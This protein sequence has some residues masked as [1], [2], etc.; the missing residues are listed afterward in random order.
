M[1]AESFKPLIRLLIKFSTFFVFIGRAWQHLYW[2]APYRSLLWDEGL[3]KPIVETLLGV[4][5]T[6]Y[7]TATTTDVWIQ[8]IIFYTGVLYLLAGGSVLFY[9][10]YQRKLLRILIILGGVN[11]VFLSFL[12]M[13]E[14]FYHFAQFFEHAIQ[15][16]LPFVFLYQIREDRDEV[17]L[18]FVLKVL[19]AIVFVSH[20]LYAIGYYPVP[21][22]F[23]DMVMGI[24][25]FSESQAKTFLSIA[26]LMD[27]LVAF[28]IFVPRVTSV[29]LWYAVVW[30]LLTAFAR[31]VSGFHMDFP[32]QT[33]H[34]EL[35][36]TLY[37]LGH[38][39]V[40][41]VALLMHR[42]QKRLGGKVSPL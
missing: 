7:V 28:Y 11:L 2:D 15:F 27:F 30:G 32:W 37:R 25:P 29:A 1:F 16:S 13:K 22:N 23:V 34:Q 39:L 21:G 24:F 26:G 19:V 35:L 40:P 9:A 6:D 5:W 36:G 18:M 8:N 38:G 41:L 31:I 42:N 20:G 17:R 14:K 10:K 3:L 4:T 12:L 33:I